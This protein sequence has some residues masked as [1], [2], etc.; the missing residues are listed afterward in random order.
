MARN[1]AERPALK[2]LIAIPA[3]NER[4]SIA[5]TI[6]GCLA[7]RD[8]IAA[9]SPVTDVEVTVVSDGSTDGTVARAERYA[10]RIK[11]I[12]FP[13][14]RGYGAAITAA[15]QE[16]DADLLGFLDADGTCDPHFFGPACH[17][18]VAR[19]AD[20]VLGCRLNRK[21]RMPPLRRVGNVLFAWMLSVLSMQ[22][23][24]DT[25]SGMRVVRRSCLP[26]ILP[27]PRGLDFTPAMSA[28]AM[29]SRDLEILELDMPYH[30]RAGR[31]KLHPLRDGVRFLRVILKMALLYRPLRLLGLVAGLLLVA[32][33]ALMIR[34]IVFYLDQGYVLEWT[35]YRFLLS[36]LL[37][38]VAAS[39]LCV[40]YL[41]QKAA[42]ISL[43]GRP[44]EDVYHG[45]G[46]WLFSRRWFP[47]LPIVLVA[48]SL[49]LVWRALAQ[50]LSTGEV[51]EHWSRVVTAM[52]P[53]SVAAILGVSKVV[54][55]TLN[56]VASRLSYLKS[57]ADAPR[58]R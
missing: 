35:V 38:S 43:S 11:L 24:R 22:R 20:I 56:L 25:A 36:E 45:P 51:T 31:S 48:S 55:F 7:A 50:Y 3:L 27:L 12:V 15:W 6:E 18:L 40:A 19:G 26:R 30:E 10:D 33:V 39:I 47:A 14:N 37:A 2:L 1:L 54:D 34:P 57:L 21:S 17:E 4:D 42:D 46:G 49:G 9:N 5:A 32:S 29:L 13:E 53:V 23:V 52:L 41:G 44:G 8:H 16:S 58:A 28:R